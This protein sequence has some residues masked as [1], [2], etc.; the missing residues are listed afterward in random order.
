MGQACLIRRFQQAGP[1]PSAWCTV[2]IES[3]TISAIGSIS[4]LVFF[5]SCSLRALRIFAV[6]K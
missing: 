4:S 1:H 2:A 3:T 6:G 5:L